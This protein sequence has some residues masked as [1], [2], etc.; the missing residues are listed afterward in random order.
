ML[1]RLCLYCSLVLACAAQ[2]PP[3]SPPAKGGNGKEP[4][5]EENRTTKQAETA[6][7]WNIYW[8]ATAIPDYHGKFHSPYSGT[9]SLRDADELDA[10]LTSTVFF[11][12]RL[13]RTTE[14]YIDPEVAGGKG[15]SNV[16]GI[17]NFPNGELPRVA[18]VVPMPYI[19]RTYI[20]QDF[21]WGDAQESVE[22]EENQ[23]AG[24]RAMDRVTVIAGRFSVTDFFDDNRYSHDP[25]S[26]FMGWAA[27]YNGA[28][29]YPA[30]TRGYTNGIVTQL[31][32]QSWTFS[33]GS[34]LEPLT[35]N[36]MRLD[37]RITRD[38][39]DIFQ[40]E[41]RWRIGKREGAVRP[42]GFLLHTDSG[43]YQEALDIASKTHATPEI[44]RTIQIGRLKYGGGFSFDQ[45]VTSSIG[46]FA[47]AGWNDGHTE[48]FAFTP[49]DRVAGGGI[50]ITGSPWHRPYDTFGSMFT[51][52]GLSAVHAA[53]LTAGGLDFMIGD[54]R[55]NYSPE[56]VWESYYSARV[57][58]GVFTGFDL[59][60]VANPA[61][62][63]DRGPV[64][65][66]SLRLH[67]E[68]GH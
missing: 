10:S 9:Y 47:R 30:D 31:H 20:Q 64:W 59:Q 13:A 57:R 44:T 2:Q 65:V 42:L 16:D 60:Y 40:I 28:F 67:A 26:Q 27:M 50:S 52:S 68:F 18:T 39:G 62:N 56:C 14:V 24:T 25:R 4:R 8:Q 1:L 36:G 45:E 11:G 19:A 7:R 21:G 23:L 15:F 43:S 29:D 46:V 32:T 34:V 5:Q 35:A 58:A 66:E 53:Y 55:L 38:R 61:Y 49:I 6:Q 33:Y 37:W 48:S 63:R 22:S 12:L 54:G 51:A 17:A 41:R 3:A